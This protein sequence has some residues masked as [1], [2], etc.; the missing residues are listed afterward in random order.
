[1]TPRSPTERLRALAGALA[2]VGLAACGPETGGEARD[3][4]HP[5]PP[6]DT[7]LARV[8]DRVITAGDFDADFRDLWMQARTE[9]FAPPQPSDYPA[10][11]RRL[12]DLEI[13][14]L[15]AER[16][17]L[18]DPRELDA[19]AER[20]R[21]RVPRDPAAVARLRR[22]LAAQLLVESRMAQGS[23]RI[24]EPD[25]DALRAAYARARAELDRPE[26]VRIWVARVADRERARRLAA[27]ARALPPGDEAGFADLARDYAVGETGRGGG[28]LGWLER[29]SSQ[30]PPEVLHTAFGLERPGAVS[31]PVPSAGGFAV[32][33]LVARSPAVRIAFDDARPLLTRRLRREALDA[34][35]SRWAA[36]LSAEME[37]EVYADVLEGL[38]RSVPP[39]PAPTP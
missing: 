38:L 26:R 36:E 12:V 13:L 27:E 24:P 10:F 16:H 14:A 29:D 15:H 7:P 17:D 18:V 28:L 37:V 32:V 39:L 8:E 3:G 23:F 19:R 5:P 31:D 6:P 20:R 4:W 30:V 35:V 11:L 22:R 1:M 25:E 2:L 33:R 21:G 34:A 9:R